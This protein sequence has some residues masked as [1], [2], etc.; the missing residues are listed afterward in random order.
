MIFI[1][2]DFYFFRLL[3]IFEMVV[4][5]GVGSVFGLNDIVFVFGILFICNK[6]LNLLSFMFEILIFIFLFKVKEWFLVNCIMILL[7]VFCIIILWLVRL[8]LLILEIIIVF[9]I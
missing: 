6:L 9:N 1:S 3:I 5:C 8:L 4:I 2:V 7:L